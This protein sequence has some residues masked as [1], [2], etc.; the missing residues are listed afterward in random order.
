[1][2]YRDPDAGRRVRVSPGR[3]RRESN[4]VH[5]DGGGNGE[6]AGLSS[7]SVS[8]DRDEAAV[9]QAT[10]A[11]KKKS[12]K[13][14]VLERGEEIDK[15]PPPPDEAPPP[16]AIVSLAAIRK[17]VGGGHGWLR[18]KFTAKPTPLVDVLSLR[19]RTVGGVVR[20]GVSRW[21]DWYGEGLAVITQMQAAN[22]SV[23][24]HSSVACATS[25]RGVV[26]GQGDRESRRPAEAGCHVRHRFARGG[27][28][29]PTISPTPV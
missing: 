13:F 27:R 22:G 15:T 14:G 4:H 9:D 11:R 23:T 1:M 26:S 28:G 6:F 7:A 12:R 3:G 8:T 18:S 24:D 5:D 10:V 17:A 25:F 20:T 16:D 19:H 21:K 2:A 29:L